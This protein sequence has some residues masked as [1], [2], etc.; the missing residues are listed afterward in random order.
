MPVSG[1]FKP[2]MRSLTDPLAQSQ[3][4]AAETSAV[5]LAAIVRKVPDFPKPGILFYDI[6]TIMADA[7]AWT[8]AIDAM[9]AN[10]AAFQPTAIAGIESRGFLMGAPVAYK[11]GLG[12][13]M[14]RKRGKLPGRVIQ[15]TYDLEYGTDTVEIVEGIVKPGSRVVLVDD[16]LATGGTAKASIDLLTGVGADVAGAAFLIELL[17]LGGAA[18]VGVPTKAVMSFGGA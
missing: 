7:T 16:L 11:L 10:V 17:N 3:E 5:D 2:A 6:S 1:S 8:C 14:V 13:V 15:H 18:R 4:T 9:A 12:L